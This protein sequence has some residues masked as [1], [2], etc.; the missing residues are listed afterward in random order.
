MR[1]KLSSYLFNFFRRFRI[2][3][4]PKNRSKN[5]TP[6]ASLIIAVYKHADFLEKVFLSLTRQSE[7]NFEVIVADDG[8]GD[9]IKEM[10][11]KFNTKFSSHFKYPIKHAWH[12]DDGFRKTIIANSA[13]M[14]SDSDYLIFIDGDCILHSKFIERHIVRAKVNH[15]QTGRR[16]MLSEEASEKM[17]NDDISS[18]LIE[19]PSYWK[20][21]M[22]VREAN[23]KYG[24]YKPLFYK[25]FNLTHSGYRIIGCNFSIHK[26]DFV[27]INGYDQRVIGRGLE[28]TNLNNRLI[29]VGTRVDYIAQEAIQ[30]HLHH[31]FEPIPHSDEVVEQFTNPAKA[32]S[33]TGMTQK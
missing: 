3:N 2:E 21:S 13:V 30:Y 12:E 22:D 6:K 15:V 33:E 14:M 26:S 7:K 31:S 18:G 17:T 32:W 10:I 16:V 11:A 5:D 29:M 1:S 23:T 24:Y 4:T 19:S 8:S 27:A 9:E 25:F 28:D 20:R